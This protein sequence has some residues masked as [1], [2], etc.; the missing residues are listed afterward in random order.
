MIDTLVLGTEK[1]RLMK[2]VLKNNEF[3]SLKFFSQR[4]SSLGP[5]MANP[6][7]D[8]TNGNFYFLTK[9]SLTE[10]PVFRCSVYTTCSACFRSKEECFWNDDQCQFRDN[11]KLSDR[12]IQCPPEVFNFEPKE[13]PKQG[14]TI[15][16]FYG[17]NFGSE[18]LQNSKD[19]YLKVTIGNKACLPLERTN[20]FF[21]CRIIDTGNDDNDV[22]QGK[23]KNV[24]QFKILVFLIFF[25]I[26]GIITINASDTNASNYHSLGYNINGKITL[27]DKFTFKSF[28]LTGVHPTYGPF[29]GATRLTIAGSDLNIGSNATVKIGKSFCPVVCS[30]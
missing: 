3:K 13:G 7:Y 14:G 30:N 22:S 5:L 6:A 21:T 11:V 2:V 29:A 20:A 9:R 26:I 15:V 16:S 10:V 19:T 12:H 17:H 28:S 24:L 25:I 4:D 27:E 8:S 18:V 1:S 23:K